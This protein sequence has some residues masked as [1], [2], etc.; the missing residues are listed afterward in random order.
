[1]TKTPAAKRKCSVTTIPPYFLKASSVLLSPVTGAD[2]FLCLYR[3]GF[4]GLVLRLIGT[5]HRVSL[6]LRG[7]RPMSPTT[8]FGGVPASWLS[9]RQSS[10]GW[11]ARRQMREAKEV[12]P[13]QV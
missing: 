3:R 10:P 6:L 7:T 11:A 5:A 13:R 2:P 4:L 8:D 9:K 12:A 1:M